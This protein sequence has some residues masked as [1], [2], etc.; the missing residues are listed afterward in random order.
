MKKAFFGAVVLGM[1]LSSFCFA[2]KVEVGKNNEIIVDGK[3]FFPIVQWGQ[4]EKLFD[5]N[6]SLGVNTFS[7]SINFVKS[8]KDYFDFCKSKGVYGVMDFNETV[9]DH[10]A[11]L[12]WNHSDEPDM[13]DKNTGKPRIPVAKSIEDYKKIKE[14]DPGHLVSVGLTAGFNEVL[15][16]GSIGHKDRSFYKEYTKAA[17]LFAF[18]VYPLYQYNR[19]ECLWYVADSVTKLRN[20]IED[21]KPV[22]P[23][24]EACAGSKW[25][26]PAKTREPFAYEIRCEVYMAVVRGAKGIIWWT[27]SWIAPENVGNPK[28]NK[29]WD[30]KKD[31]YYTQLGVTAGNKVEMKKI[32]AQLTRLTPVIYSPDVENKV[33]TNNKD[34][35]VLVKEYAGKT[36]IFAVNVKRA[37]IETEFSVAGMKKTAKIEVD[38]EV[39]TVASAGEGSFTDKFSEHAVHIYCV[40]NR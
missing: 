2:A 29:R 16:E 35:E 10:P 33:K 34:I 17:D 25:I 37:V 7:T 15:A 38:D 36:Y 19:P 26:T 13:L 8:P 12:F 11:V 39:R 21:K 18:D 28:A 31:K 40:E 4:S 20:I 9:K 27:H 5:E 1:C 6:I 32:N 3:L 30:G 14:K 23:A 24:I 22:L